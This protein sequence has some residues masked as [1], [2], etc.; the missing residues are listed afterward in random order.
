M[1][2]AFLHLPRFPVQRRRPLL[3]RPAAPEAEP[4][5]ALVHAV[6]GV[7]RVAFASAHASAQGVRGGMAL[8]AARALVPAL[9]DLPYDPAEEDR[10]LASAAEGL[11][12]L[13]PA[14]MPS[15]PDGLWLD[16]SAAP[17]FGGEAGL[18]RRALSHLLGLGLRARGAVASELFTARALARF[19]GGRVTVVSPGGS[20]EALA[21]LPLQALEEVESPVHASLGAFG[22]RTLGEV[23]RL[24]PAQVGVRLGT[25]GLRAIALARGGDDARFLPAPLPEQ[26][27]EARTLDAPAEA[28]EPLLFVLKGMVDALCARLRGRSRAALRLTLT[29]LLEPDGP[30]EVP[31]VLARPSN[32]PRLLLDLLRSRLEDLRLPAPVATVVLGVKTWCQDPGQQRV[33]GALP[34]GDA[35]LESVLARLATALGPEALSSPRAAEDHRPEAA[36]S[37]AP[38]QPPVAEQGVHAEARRASAPRPAPDARSA[39]RPVRLLPRPAPLPVDL[40]PVGELRSARLFGRPRAVLGLAGPERLSGQW[41]TRGPFARDYYRVHFEGLGPTWIFR[42]A[43]DGRFYLHGFF[44]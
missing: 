23:A 15:P 7:Q 19:G 17:L 34:E 14:Y 9:V 29:L 4:P 28:L 39:E 24:V 8:T 10:A 25:R 13:A 43:R 27:E 6:R 18:L 11:L 1:R 32:V 2:V 20:A 40:G 16:A 31:L 42:D 35:G 33:L 41:W 5:L 44:D 3:G 36:R 30:R 12:V 37:S 22:L 21:L 38:F 26:I